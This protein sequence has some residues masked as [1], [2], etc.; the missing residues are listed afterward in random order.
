[1]DHKTIFLA[2]LAGL[3]DIETEIIGALLLSKFQ[4]AAMSRSKLNPRDRNPFYLYIDEVQRFITTSLNTVFSE[5]RKYGLHMVVANQYLRQLAG[6]TLEAIVGNTGTTIMFRL[7]PHD[8]TAM[9]PFVQP[10][11]GSETLL[12][13]NRFQ[14]L[15]KMRFQGNTMP[16]FKMNT[17]L[18]PKLREV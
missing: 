9:A 7:G 15:V 5:A 3:P 17:L 1:M 12:N 11:F 2:N 14:A 8:A 10:Q 6:E 13:L 16:A 18:A 4:A